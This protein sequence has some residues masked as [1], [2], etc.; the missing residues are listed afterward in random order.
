MTQHNEVFR[1]ALHRLWWDRY[2]IC[3][4]ISSYA[5][6]RGHGW[7]DIEV[8]A[9]QLNQGELWHKFCSRD[10]FS[11]HHPLHSESC[12]SSYSQSCTETCRHV[13]RG[14]RKCSFLKTFIFKLQTHNFFFFTKSV[15]YGVLLCTLKSNKDL[16]AGPLQN[17]FAVTQTSVDSLY[18]W[19]SLFKVTEQLR[20]MHEFCNPVFA[21]HYSAH[22]YFKYT[23]CSGI[24]SLQASLGIFF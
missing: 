6:L 1:L 4:T 21:R 18:F 16:K 12:K 23:R 20:N 14:H 11:G 24:N 3:A 22:G 15:F 19:L 17:K 8:P 7:L 10:C 9:P 5:W 2:Q 13:L